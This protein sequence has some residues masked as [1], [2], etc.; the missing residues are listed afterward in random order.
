[1]IE[2]AHS[3]S[4]TTA[5]T[6]QTPSINA[7]AA[8]PVSI[9]PNIMIKIATA[10]AI[11]AKRHDLRD[12]VLIDHAPNPEQNS[13]GAKPV[14]ELQPANISI[15]LFDEPRHSAVPYPVS[16]TYEDSGGRDA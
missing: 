8:P 15:L 5:R 7:A 14:Q 2:T 16:S 6:R 13:T 3:A 10:T 1:V 9:T 12:H 11:I 4:P